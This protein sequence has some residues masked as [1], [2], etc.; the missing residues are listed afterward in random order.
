V[1]IVCL[2]SRPFIDGSERRC[3]YAFEFA[4]GDYVQVDNV[5]IRGGFAEQEDPDGYWKSAGADMLYG[6][7]IDDSIQVPAE[8]A[9]RMKREARAYEASED[10]FKPWAAGTP[11]YAEADGPGVTH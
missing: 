4:N 7:T 10:A 8:I 2:Q 6:A 9:E 1:Q 5:A 3:S 11:E